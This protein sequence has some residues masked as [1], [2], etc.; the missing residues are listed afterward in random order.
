MD[1][2]VVEI[3]VQGRADQTRINRILRMV[4][5]ERKK[6][7]GGWRST[8]PTSGRGPGQPSCTFESRG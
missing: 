7:K 5:M 4:M 3:Q 6:W 8:Y 1:T 2:E